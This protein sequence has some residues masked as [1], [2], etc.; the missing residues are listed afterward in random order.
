M[1]T[2]LVNE[3]IKDAAALKKPGERK[4]NGLILIDGF[5]EIEMALRAQVEIIFLFYCLELIK[6]K[7]DIFNL[8]DSGKRIEVSEAAFKKICYKENPD[9]FLAIARPENKKLSDLKLSAETLVVVLENIEKPG[10]LGGIIRTA[11]AAGAEAVIIN[12]GQ[13]DIYNPNVIRAS[14]GHVFLENIISAPVSAT[15]KWLKKNKIK[16]FG[17]ATIG[18]RVYTEVDL[19]GRTAIVLG[20]EAEGLSKKWLEEAD[21]LIKIP[22][23]EGID[24]LN[25]SVAAGIIIYEA[26][27][28]RMVEQE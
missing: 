18:A 7:T 11:Y 17:A 9:G 13:T 1:I 8:V 5:R 22:M 25:V 12:S 19:R 27:R 2:S 14:E 21:K 6:D 4:K 16:S 20:S 26:L 15:I 23:K 10:N 24:S 28:Q 3:M